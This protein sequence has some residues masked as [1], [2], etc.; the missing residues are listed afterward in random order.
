MG[1]MSY[2]K[3]GALVVLLAG[4][5]WAKAYYE[6]SQIE[7][8]QL[9]ENVIKLEIAVQR[10]EAAVKSLQVGIKKSH[11]AHDI[12]TQRFAKARQEN[13]KLKELLGKHDL[14]FLAQR[15]PG[16]IEKR[17]NKGTRNANRCFEIVSG[18]PLTQAERKATKP[19]EINSSCPELANP[20]F[21]VVQ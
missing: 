19:S 5:W 13:S 3:I 1:I 9:K 2:I 7:I 16:L 8:A 11:K 17:V 20:N 18:S 21:K 10:S 6:N 12:V 15:K 4:L 14:G